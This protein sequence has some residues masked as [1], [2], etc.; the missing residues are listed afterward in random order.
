MAGSKSYSAALFWRFSLFWRSD[1]A[2][3][4][5]RNF[6]RSASQSSEPMRRNFS[7]T[8]TFISGWRRLVF[9]SAS[10][11]SKDG[12]RGLKQQPGQDGELEADALR[13]GEVEHRRLAARHHVEQARP[14][15][16]LRHRLDL[17]LRLRRL[18]KSHV[19]AGGER[20]VHP[21][22]RLLEADH[23]AGI[24]A[25]DQQEVRVGLCRRGGA[26][27]CQ[28]VFKRDHRLV[29]EVPALLGKPLVLDVQPC[30]PAPL[31]FAHRAGD[32][33][34]VAVAGIGVGDHRHLHGRGDPPGIV[35]HLVHGHE[36]EIRIAERRR[37]AGP[38]HVDRGKPRLVDGAGADAVVGAGRH[39]HAVLP[40]QGAQAGGRGKGLRGHGSPPLSGSRPSLGEGASVTRQKRN[41]GPWIGPVKQP[42]PDHPRSA[43][44]LAQQRQVTDAAGIRTHKSRL[45]HHG[46]MDWLRSNRMKVMLIRH[47]G[48]R[49]AFSSETNTS[50]ISSLHIFASSHHAGPSH[51]SQPRSDTTSTP[52]SELDHARSICDRRSAVAVSP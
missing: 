10:T 29:V 37:G 15:D 19:G 52:H 24:G 31:V 46:S 41:V 38:R 6:S 42:P 21:R 22:H 14:L 44:A 50:R 43:I 36:P 32:V 49:L 48:F 30:H 2:T 7:F 51:A 16:Q 28:I 3:E 23:G 45:P 33:E 8:L 9:T 25:S 40:E 4:G 39:D 47:L 5:V 20:R 27:L 34:L 12:D 13:I 1:S 26:D 35:R 17:G 18:E 11:A